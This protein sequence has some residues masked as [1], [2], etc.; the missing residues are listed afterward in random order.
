MLSLSAELTIADETIFSQEYVLIFMA[1][2][3]SINVVLLNCFDLYT[4][5]FLAEFLRLARKCN[6]Y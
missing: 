5:R 2:V 3:R 6:Q 1:V 4:R